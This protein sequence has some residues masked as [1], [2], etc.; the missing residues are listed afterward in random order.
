V[1]QRFHTLR[2]TLHVGVYVLSSLFRSYYSAPIGEP[3]IVMSV[4]VCLSVCLSVCVSVCLCP[5]SHLR[6][7]TSDIHFIFN[8]YFLIL[9]IFVHGTCGRGSV[10]LW[11]LR[12]TLCSFGFMD[13]VYLPMSQCCSTSPPSSSSGSLGLSYKLW[14]V[15]PVAG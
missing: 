10:L 7:Y 3:S 8:F 13:D 14:T 15:I 5:R 6:N 9:L 2:V 12:D 11:R 1:R 4:S